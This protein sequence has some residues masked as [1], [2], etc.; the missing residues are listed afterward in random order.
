MQPWLAR[1]E[2]VNL[3]NS[4]HFLQSRLTFG[5]PRQYRSMAEGA[6]ELLEREM[7]QNV[8]KC[9]SPR[10]SFAAYSSPPMAGWW[11]RPVFLQRLLEAHF[12]NAEKQDAPAIC[13]DFDVRR[14]GGFR[15][16]E[17]SE[18]FFSTTPVHRY[19]FV[20]R[21]DVDLSGLRWPSQFWHRPTR[22]LQP[23]YL[24]RIRPNGRQSLSQ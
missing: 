16:C 7:S 8:P 11:P 17:N 21:T 13:N 5:A 2:R 14:A 12:P 10:K 19:T 18:S 9:P 24:D 4:I 3:D 22:P 6:F 1:G 15:A 20:T 23:E